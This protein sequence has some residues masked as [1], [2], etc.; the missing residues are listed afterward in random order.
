M[1]GPGALARLV[2]G[3][4]LA[5][6]IA[7]AARRARS[8]STSGAVAATL[9]GAACVAAGWAWGA[10]LV[11][12]FVA[13]SALSRWKEDAKARRTAGIVAKGGERDA[14]QV[15]ANGGLYALAAVATLAL[16]HPAL[17]GAALGALA[18]ATADTWGTEVGTLAR[19]TPR[20]VTSWRAVPAGTSGAV[21]VPGSLATAGGALFIGGVAL[22]LGFRGAPVAAGVLAGILG[23][24]TDSLLGATVQSRR[25]C[26]ACAR[27]TERDVHDCGARTRPAGGWGWLDND[28]VNVACVATGALAG[29]GLAA[30]LG[31]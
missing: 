10:L 7:V 3:L 9:V 2:A 17:V 12:Y 24:A 6:A 30:L 19:G 25:W 1:A 29:G 20:L 14:M 16:P 5:A 22:L 18:A 8:L 11:T 28:R 27:P 26:E 21:S 23:A 13:S 4:A 31:A 15:V